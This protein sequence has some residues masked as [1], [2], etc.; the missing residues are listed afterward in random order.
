MKTSL[1]IVAVLIVLGGGVYFVVQTP[2]AI[3]PEEVI[4]GTSG[5]R[6][7]TNAPTT[8]EETVTNPAPSGDR[9]SVYDGI[10]VA[11]NVRELNLSGKNLSGSL[12][13]E[14]RFLSDLEVLNLSS[15]D[16]TGLPAEV[17]QLSKLRILNLSDNPFT[18]LPQELGNLKNLEV[19]DLRGTNYSEF[20]LKIISER[21]PS[22][23]QVLTD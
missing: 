21:L 15:N 11:S 17:G 9:I 12:K 20:D 6:E 10:S 14:V 8:P 19:L 3:A 16:F 18:G 23:T 1:I 2:T 5:N 4:E 7:E 13:A 22:N